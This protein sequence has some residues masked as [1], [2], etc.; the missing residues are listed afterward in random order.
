MS[1]NPATTCRR[2]RAMKGKKKMTVMTHQRG[3]TYTMP[4]ARAHLCRPVSQ[5][6]CARRVRKVRRRHTGPHG[7][8][9]TTADCDADRGEAVV[10]RREVIADSRAIADPVRPFVRDDGHQTVLT[11]AASSGCRDW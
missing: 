1:E 3:P 4:P 2:H 9:R 8:V 7:T 6:R 10:K 5:S 11:Y